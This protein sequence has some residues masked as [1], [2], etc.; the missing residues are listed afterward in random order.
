MKNI[1]M[2]HFVC[3]D[4]FQFSTSTE[5]YSYQFITNASYM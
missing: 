1:A 5:F 3:D 4:N 2:L